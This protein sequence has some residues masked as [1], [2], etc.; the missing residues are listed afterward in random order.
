MRFAEPALPVESRMAEDR[1]EHPTGT[2]HIAAS[3]ENAPGSSSRWSVDASGRS[4]VGRVRTNNEDHFLVARIDRTWRTVASN[5]PPET[6]P[7]ESTE[8][9]YGMLVADGMGGRAAGEVASRTAIATLVDLVLHTPDVIM[10]LDPA[11]TEEV[12]Q[13]IDQRFQRI[14]AVL[15]EQVRLDPNLAGMGTTMTLAASIGPDLV[16][17]HVGD[18]RAYLY[19]QRELRQLTRDQTMAQFLADAGLITAAELDE[20]PLRHVLTNVLGTQEGEML[21]D[22]TGLRLESGD[23]LLL[24]SDG[25]TEMVS[26]AAI[27]EVLAAD[28][29]ASATLCDRLIDLALTAGGKD[30]VTVVVGRYVDHQ[31]H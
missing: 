2:H 30:N 5:V 27:A 17:G 18:S 22:L 24:C 31:G 20:H 29:E 28:G 1:E 23:I 10:R 6:I 19:H 11:L 25:L 13:R 9:A 21:V 4:H 16:I 8:T 12:L 7:A 3:V 15:T 14:K 26:E